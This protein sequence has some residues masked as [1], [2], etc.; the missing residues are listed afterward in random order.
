MN[1][2]ETMRSDPMPRFGLVVD[3]NRCTG[4]MTCV[5]ACKEENDTRPGIWW[6]R[7]L[8]VES[9]RLDSITYVRYACM[10]C[11]DPPCIDA[12]SE[13]AISKRSDGIVLIDKDK[14]K[15]SGECAKAC[16]YGLIEMNPDQDYF[17]EEKGYNQ[18]SNPYYKKHPPG[19]ASKCNF[20]VH[21]IDKGRQPACVESCP[22]KALIFGDLDDPRS[23]IR[24]KIWQAEP[25]LAHQN[26]KPKSFYIIPKDF[27]CILE[28]RILENPKMGNER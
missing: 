5:L 24:E 27:I 18:G 21:R 26:T 23:T 3:L 28:D 17:P 2:L 25:L 9:E 1:E 20:C 22:S 4:C 10:H 6:N 16:P 15:A 7:I 8:E 13:G 11:D 19:K 14:C 12:C